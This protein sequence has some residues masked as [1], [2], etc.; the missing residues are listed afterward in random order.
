MEQQIGAEIAPEELPKQ[1][2]G[3]PG[4]LQPT[5]ETAYRMPDLPY[6]DFTEMQAR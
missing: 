3:A 6:A 4:R 2:L 1:R 5:F